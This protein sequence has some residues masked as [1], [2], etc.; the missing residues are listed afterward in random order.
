MS[1]WISISG[2]RYAFIDNPLVPRIGDNVVLNTAIVAKPQNELTYRVI[3]VIYTI[4]TYGSVFDTPIVFLGT[5]TQR[6][7]FILNS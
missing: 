5:I 2:K 6:V 4:G 1:F 7:A 3:D